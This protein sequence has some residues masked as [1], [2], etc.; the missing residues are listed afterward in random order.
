M[1]NLKV[2]NLEHDGRKVPNQF[3]ISYEEDNKYYKIFKSYSSMIIKWENGRM[4][5]VGKDWDYSKTTGKYRNKITK[6]TKKEFKE[7]LEIDFKW[8]DVTQVYK[9][10]KK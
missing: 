1:I 3:V 2:E 6:L 7:M 8:D 9:I 4:V 10:K 5:E